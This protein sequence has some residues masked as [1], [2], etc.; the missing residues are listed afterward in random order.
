M[1]LFDRSLFESARTAVLAGIGAIVSLS[2]SAHATW[3]ILIADTR[4]GEIVIGS[5]TCVEL[6]NLQHSTPVLISGIGAVTAQSAVDGSGMNRQIIRDRLLQGVPLDAVLE[7]LAMIDAGHDNRQYGFITAGGHTLTYSGIQNANWAGGMTGRIER[8]QPGFADDIVYSVQGN[9]LSG[10]NV[11]E[12]AVD[13][14]LAS[15]GDLPQMMMDAMQAAKSAGGDGR[16]SCSNANPTGCGSPPPAPFKSADVGYMLGARIGD[17][18]AVRANYPIDGF[19][20]DLATIDLDDDGFDEV[21]V[22]NRDNDELYIFKNTAMPGDPLSSLELWQTIQGP[23]SGTVAIDVYSHQR[24]AVAYAD[25]PRMALYG[26]GSQGL[27]EQFDVIDLPGTPSDFTQGNFDPATR[28]VSIEDTNQVIFFDTFTDKFKQTLT[29]DLNFTPADIKFV[30]LDGA[31]FNDLIVA[32]PQNNMVHLYTGGKGGFSFLSSIN[33]S[34]EPIN[35]KTA[36][37]DLDGDIEILVQCASGRKIEVFSFENDQWALWGSVGTLGT[38]IGFDV[39]PMNPGDDFPDIVTTVFATNRNLQLQISDGMGGF[40]QQTRT[41]VGPSAR[42]VF[43]SDMNNNGDLDIVVGSGGSDG[44]IILDNPRDHIL[45][46]PGR[47]AE[48]DYFMSLNVP[49]QRRSDPDPVDQLQALYDDWQLTREGRVDAVRSVVSGRQRV[50]IGSSI[51]LTIELRDL[52]GNLLPITDPAQVRPR[53]GDLIDAGAVLNIAPGIFELTVDAGDETG[54]DT[55]I[56]EAGDA[57]D[58]VQLMPKTELFVTMN[59]ADFNADGR[60]TFIDVSLFI[61]AFAARHPDAD[62]LNSGGI[63]FHDVSAFIQSYNVCN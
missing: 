40:T 9:I 43:L 17:T 52:H 32:D 55:L 10:G 50:T 1:R 53:P 19:V 13:A 60:C 57:N 28:G 8:G 34:N 26:P 18:D 29:L 47:F 59:D 39:G 51:T 14:I 42:S 62:I 56:I 23:A 44:L 16:C 45:P 7:E 24:F 48:G 5:A 6:I 2:G 36:D 22:G 46:Q 54:M 3:S 41:R 12:A 63:D 37:M 35:V 20:G 4:T 30:R 21:V 11:V 25:P 61:Q 33:T 58:P 38:G 15:G 27:T 49:N 31:G